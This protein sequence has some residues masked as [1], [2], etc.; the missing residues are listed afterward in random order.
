MELCNKDHFI[1]KKLLDFVIYRIFDKL[2][3]DDYFNFVTMKS[4]RRPHVGIP[5]EKVGI[6]SNIKRRFLKDLNMISQKQKEGKPSKRLGGAIIRAFT[7]SEVHINQTKTLVRRN[8]SSK[9][10]E[11]LGPIK[12]TVAIVGPHKQDLDLL[13]RHVRTNVFFD[14]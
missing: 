7:D 10:D 5:L 3:P 9:N 6:N 13:N 14:A 11:Y 12:F 2:G 1:H 4:G 8:N